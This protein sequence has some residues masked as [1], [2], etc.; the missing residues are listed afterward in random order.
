ML[1]KQVDEYGIALLMIFVLK[2]WRKEMQCMN[3]ANFRDR[4][5]TVSV[6]GLIVFSVRQFVTECAFFIVPPV[7]IFISVF[8]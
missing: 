1:T 4:H 2:F 5:S 8:Y 3:V 6:T 7:M